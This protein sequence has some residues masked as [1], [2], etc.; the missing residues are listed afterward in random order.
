MVQLAVFTAI[1]AIFCFTPLGSLPVGPGIVATLAHI[2]ALIVAMTLGKKAALYMGGI[3]GIFS[4]MVWTFMPPNP[5]YAFCFSPFMPNGNIWSL[6]ICVVP[7][8]IFPFIAAIIFEQLIKVFSKKRNASKPKVVAAGAISAV[9]SSLIHSILV[10]GGIYIAF[11]GNAEISQSIIEQAG[12]NADIG[13][14]ADLITFLIAWGWFNSICEAIV[15]GI[16][17]GACVVPLR[18]VTRSQN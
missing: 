9:I 6:V 11:G 3:M 7:R 13:I 18:K 17:C 4:L 2:P 8:T 5:L 10:L 12:A 16:V 15:A 14:S 1:E